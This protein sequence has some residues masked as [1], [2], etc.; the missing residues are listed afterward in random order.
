MANKG[1]TLARGSGPLPR[2]KKK[3]GKKGQLG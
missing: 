1:L 3:E 2:A